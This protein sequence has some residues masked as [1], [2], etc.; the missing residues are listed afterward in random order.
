MEHKVFKIS[1]KL[2]ENNNLELKQTVEDFLLAKERRIAKGNGNYDD[3][4]YKLSKS[5]LTSINLDL[6]STKQSDSAIIDFLKTE[7]IFRYWKVVIGGKEIR[8]IYPY[9][10]VENND[11]F[12]AIVLDLRNTEYNF[13][14]ED[15]VVEI[16][17]ELEMYSGSDLE[18]IEITEDEFREKAR[19]ELFK[20]LD[21]RLWKL[22]NRDHLI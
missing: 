4:S 12:F 10:Y 9:S 17:R 3:P 19:N 5:L 18:F 14:F 11:S 15:I 21:N 16:E 7:S 22:K 2:L 8:Y 20:P 6:Q 1:D 13:K